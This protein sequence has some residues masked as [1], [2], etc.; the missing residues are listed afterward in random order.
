MLLLKACN[1]CPQEVVDAACRLLDHFT[2]S[3]NSA[4][5]LMPDPHPFNNEGGKLG[6]EEGRKPLFG[7]L[8][9]DSCVK[10]LQTKG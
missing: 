4:G 3:R 5:I 6:T 1:G 2:E 10:T 9:G 7:A 8:L